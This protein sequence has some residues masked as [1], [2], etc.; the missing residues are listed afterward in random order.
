MALVFSYYFIAPKLLSSS[1]EHPSSQVS[2]WH[3]GH[4]ASA[5]FWFSDRAKEGCAQGWQEGKAVRS[6]HSLGT[7]GILLS[8][9]LCDGQRDMECLGEIDGKASAPVAFW[10]DCL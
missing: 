10:R 7:V 1:K 9:P 6:L 4:S 5:C 8:E 3:S 2:L